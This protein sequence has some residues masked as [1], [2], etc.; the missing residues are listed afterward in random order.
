[1]QLSII[2]VLSLAVAGVHAGNNFAQSCGRTKLDASKLELSSECNDGLGG[3]SP[4]SIL[5]LNK[6]FHVLQRKISCG[7][8]G[9]S[10]CKCSLQGDSAMSCNCGKAAGQQTVDLNACIGNNAG[11]LGC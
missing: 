11:V 1:M 3:G 8:G 7:P 6:C 2:T 4:T 9:I 10:G 5:D